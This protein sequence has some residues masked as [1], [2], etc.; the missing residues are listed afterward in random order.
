MGQVELIIQQVIVLLL[1]ILTGFLSGR[2]GYLPENS[3]MYI[4]RVV[5]KITAPALIV[6]TMANYSFTADTLRDGLQVSA[7]AVVFV[8]FSLGLASGVS[9]LLRLKGTS[10]DMYRV[11]SMF[12][13]VG[14]LALPLLNSIFGERGLVYGVFFV[15]PHD[16]LF[17]TFGVYLMC[18][19]QG[20]DWKRNI[21]KLFNANTVSFVLGLAFAFIN[22][23]N[24]VKTSPVV[25]AIYKPLYNT[26]N[27]LGKTTLYLVMLFI[28]LSL[29]ENRLGGARELLGKYPT[30]I[31]A[32]FKLLVVPAAALG[33]FILLGGQVSPFVKTIV[34]LELAMPCATI[35]PALAA[36]YGADYRFATENV[37]FTTAMSMITLSFA[38]L[39]LGTG[40]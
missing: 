39:V 30:L 23:Q 19:H 17:W 1:L 7:F 21:R 27:P 40:G 13:N 11:H 33:V 31:L 16:I 38:L 20:N 2:S 3:G 18:R 26:F 10:S 12:G 32:F 15:I 28:G 6:T 36:E 34:V 24:Y 14:Y 9:R 35:V 25:E 8:F 4:S 22:L 5:I 37:L 29:A